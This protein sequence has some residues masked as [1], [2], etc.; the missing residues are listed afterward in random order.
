MLINLHILSFNGIYLSFASVCFDL[1]QF[2]SI[3]FD[4]L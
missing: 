1:L 3:Y 2:A 4:L